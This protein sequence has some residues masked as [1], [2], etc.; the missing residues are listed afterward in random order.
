MSR[1]TVRCRDQTVLYS[2]NRFASDS[3]YIITTKRS[4]TALH[5]AAVFPACTIQDC[6]IFTI[7]TPGATR[8]QSA[9]NCET[10]EDTIQK[11]VN[12]RHWEIQSYRFISRGSCLTWF[13]WEGR[14]GGPSASW[15]MFR[16]AFTGIHPIV[17]YNSRILACIQVST[18][19][20]VSSGSC[21]SELNLAFWCLL[22]DS[23]IQAHH[24]RSLWA[25]WIIWK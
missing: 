3:Q 22:M 1:V 12:R 9:V 13:H 4:K 21:S 14:C 15:S 18:D 19:K 23:F 11:G 20:A 5:H 2:V 10:L 25:N 17:P 6:C 8:V 16:L 7:T 24:S